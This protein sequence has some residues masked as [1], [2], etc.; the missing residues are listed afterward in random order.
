[1]NI[2]NLSSETQIQTQIKDRDFLKPD[3]E[4]GRVELPMTKLV[5]QVTGDT[6][7]LMDGW[8]DLGGRGGGGGGKKRGRVEI[9]VQ[10]R[11]YQ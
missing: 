10:Y 11:G 5:G 1:L 6:R 3:D 4:L 9:R 2:K 7:G 8:F